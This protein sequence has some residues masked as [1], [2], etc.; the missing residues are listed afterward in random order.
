M[1]VFLRIAPELHLKR[2]LVG[3][4]EKVYEINR[5]FR[6][7]GVSQRHN[8]EFTMLEV[9]E[10]W[11]DYEGMMR[12]C[13]EIISAIA[14]E[15]FGSLKIT[16]QDKEI[17]F[18]TPWQ[19]HSFSD[20]VKEKFGITA[21]DSAEAM[22]KKIKDKKKNI[23]LEGKLTRSAVMKIVEDLLQEKENYNPVFFTDYFS[24]LSPLAKVKKDNP[25]VAERF[26]LFIAGIEVGNAYTEQNDPVEQK[27][28]FEDDIKENP[29]NKT[30]D[31]DFINALEYGM[32]PAGGLGIG[33]DRLIMLFTN[34]ASIR[35]VILF[36][37]LRPEK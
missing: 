21:D 8:P 33:I 14:K 26:E 29:D 5:S 7:E 27:K 23:A 1:D 19:R 17:D 16:Y 30:I 28:R 35:E 34:S 20:V 37:L 6:N 15:I 36:P 25:A 10:A 22:L 4:F 32:P 11:S 24:V 3:G 31:E 13:E 18:T 12:L 9:Y 2:L